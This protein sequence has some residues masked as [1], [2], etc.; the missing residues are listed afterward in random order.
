MNSRRTDLALEAKQIWENS[1]RKTTRLEGVIAREEQGDGYHI[2]EVEVINSAGEKALGKPRGKYVTLEL[3]QL[4]RREKA[5]YY[6]AAELVAEQ[7][8]GLMELA[9]DAPVLVVGLG[10]R[11]MTPD[12]VGP[13]AMESLLVT[14]HLTQNM[15]QQFGMLRPVTALITGVMGDTGMESGELVLAVTK[16]LKPAAVIA[17]DALAARST[18]RLFTTVQLTNTGISPGSGVGNHRMALDKK[19]LGVPVI[20]VGVPTVVDAATLC[21]DLLEQA[22]VAV[23]EAEK[24]QQ[25]GLFVTPRDVD[26]SADTV[27]KV[28]GLGISRALQPGLTLEDVEMFLA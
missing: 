4:C 16:R 19:T 17:V 25:K 14:R 5:D 21:M 26:S 20:G 6:S 11:A 13:K 2:T 24:I 15:P 18:D 1:A 23:G 28:L 9:P 10:N 27:S 7:L 8:L 3:P 12:A 22:G